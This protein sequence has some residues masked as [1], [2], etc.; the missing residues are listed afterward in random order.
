MCVCVSVCMELYALLA[1]EQDIG[2]AWL[3][4]P[5]SNEA[6]LKYYIVLPFR[7][8]KNFKIQQNEL[9]Y[10]YFDINYINTIYDF[11]STSTIIFSL[12]FRLL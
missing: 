2:K 4:V 8:L 9:V 7:L 5:D 6:I 12:Y 11:V 1:A 3:Y 10:F